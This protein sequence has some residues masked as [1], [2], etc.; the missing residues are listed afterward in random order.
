[1]PPFFVVPVVPRIIWI[2]FTDH[3]W[4]AD[5]IVGISVLEFSRDNDN[6]LFKFTEMYFILTFYRLYFKA[7]NS[8]ANSNRYFWKPHAI[9]LR[10]GC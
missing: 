3:W 9:R 7:L 4:S 6:T 8:N 1:L 10:H 5:H 2:K